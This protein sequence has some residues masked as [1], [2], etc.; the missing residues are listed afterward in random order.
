MW[1]LSLWRVRS[2][3]EGDRDRLGARSAGAFNIH[4]LRLAHLLLHT[5][6]LLCE[7]PS[8][9]P[10][11]GLGWCRDR[12]LASVGRRDGLKW[13]RGSGWGGVIVTSLSRP[14][15]SSSPSSPPSESALIR[16]RLILPSHAS[17]LWSGGRGSVFLWVVDVLVL[18]PLTFPSLPRTPLASDDPPPPPLARHL[19]HHH[20]HPLPIFAWSRL[21]DPTMSTPEYDY[22]F[23]LLLI[24]DSGV[25]K[26]CLLLRF[27]DDTYTES[28][29]S[30]IGVSA[31]PSLLNA[32][33]RPTRACRRVGSKDEGGSRVR[34]SGQSGSRRRPPT[35]G[36]LPPIAQTDQPRLRRVK[37]RHDTNTDGSLYFTRSACQVDFKIRTIELEGKTVKLQIVSPARD[38]ADNLASSWPTPTSAPGRSAYASH[39]DRP[40]SLIICALSGT[41][42][43]RLISPFRSAGDSS[44]SAEKASEPVSDGDHRRSS[45]LA[46]FL[47]SRRDST[48]EPVTRCEHRREWRS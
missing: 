14:V 12:V 30:T 1:L 20:R 37:D 33:S 5:S 6:L 34:G 11:K 43:V 27:A 3:A 36:P 10:L 23:K 24:G 35:F 42:P 13:A 4:H 29:I 17:F 28:Y 2:L 47:L 41:L 45:R 32:F 19:K 16:L 21:S 7:S 44:L 26:S 15:P 46:C 18:T 9:S 48:L 38:P 8:S 25:G 40:L 39:A 31:H 22:L